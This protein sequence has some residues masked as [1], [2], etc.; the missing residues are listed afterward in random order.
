MRWVAVD[1]PFANGLQG[2]GT[3]PALEQVGP[4]GAT[5]S[6]CGAHSRIAREETMAGLGDKIGGKAEELKGKA[7]GDKAEQA[8]GKARQAKGTVKDKVAKGR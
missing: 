6:E 5:G 4:R 1:A 7:T 2:S 8:K 3:R